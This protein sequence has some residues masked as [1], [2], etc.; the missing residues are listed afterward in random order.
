MDCRQ[1]SKPVDLGSVA[2]D[3][4]DKLSEDAGRAGLL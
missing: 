4:T 1:D 2:H 3:D